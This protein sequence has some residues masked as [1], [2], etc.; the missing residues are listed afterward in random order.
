MARLPLITDKAGLDPRQAATFDWI[1]ESRGRMI[2][3]YEV[4]LHAPDLARP[5][6]ELGHLIRF[7]G[8]LSG[9]DRELAI[10]TVGK[11]HGCQFEWDSHIDLAREAGVSQAAEVVLTGGRAEL[12]DEEAVIIGFVQELCSSSRVSDDTFSSAV[13]VLG[14]PAVVELTTLVGYYTMLSYVMAVADVCA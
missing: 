14:T 7:E 12:D 10:L 2:R 8:T 3:P 5:A 6:A 4:M 13:A 1:V 11:A 9:R